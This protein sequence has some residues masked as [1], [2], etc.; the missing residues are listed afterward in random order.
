MRCMKWLLFALVTAGLLCSCGLTEGVIQKDPK[1]YFKFSG[2]TK[3]AMVYIDD[4]A[5]IALNTDENPDDW[6]TLYEISPGKHKIIVKKNGS[7]V[8]NRIVLLGSGIT[9]EINVP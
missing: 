3:N 9:R 5:P 6:S 4:L 7:V 1:S 8:V 2:N